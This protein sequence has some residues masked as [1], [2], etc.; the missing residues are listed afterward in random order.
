MPNSSCL[1]LR[2]SISSSGTP[3]PTGP[4]EAG[5]SLFCPP[6]T[7]CVRPLTALITRNSHPHVWVFP[8][9]LCTSQGQG[10]CLIRSHRPHSQLRV[11]L[12]G[13]PGNA[14]ESKGRRKPK[15]QKW[16]KLCPRDKNWLRLAGPW[17]SGRVQGREAGARLGGDQCQAQDVVLKPCSWEHWHS[18]M[19]K[20]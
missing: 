1:E 20:I 9:Q 16:P 4:G 7:S 3:S 17:G 19:F 12:S 10:L 18:I 6:L 15:Y 8:T 2:L 11:H 14:L 13:C 5:C